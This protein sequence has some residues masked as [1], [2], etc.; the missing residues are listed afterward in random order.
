MKETEL[1]WIAGIIEGEGTVTLK[2]GSTRSGN[3]FPTLRVVMTDE[4]VIRSLHRITGLGN[5]H[6]QVREDTEKGNKRKDTW[7]WAVAARDEVRNILEQILPWMHSRR[8]ERIKEALILLDRP[9]KRQPPGQ[10]KCGTT[11]GYSA[12]Q[13]RGETFCSPCKE[14]RRLYNREWERKDRAKKKLLQGKYE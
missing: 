7:I 11:S 9:F 2:T 6:Y 5:I 8:T 13:R 14:A 12:H 4:D 3:N 1:A 10:V